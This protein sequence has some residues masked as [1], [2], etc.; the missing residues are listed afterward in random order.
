MTANSAGATMNQ[1]QPAFTL[2]ARGLARSAAPS[3]VQEMATLHAA[4][5]EVETA[6]DEQPLS[7]A[8]RG[9]EETA[10][11]GMARLSTD[12]RHTTLAVPPS[13]KPERTKHS[14]S[15]LQANSWPPP[16]PPPLLLPPSPRSPPTLCGQWTRQ[17]RRRLLMRCRPPHRQRV[18]PPRIWLPLQRRS[19]R[20]TRLLALPT[21]ASRT[22]FER[23]MRRCAR[24]TQLPS[25][26]RYAQPA[27]A[28]ASLTLAPYHLPRTLVV[29]VHP[30]L[31]P[32]LLAPPHVLTGSGGS[33]VAAGR[34][35]CGRTPSHDH[36][37]RHRCLWPRAMLDRAVQALRGRLQAGRDLP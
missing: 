5:Q 33:R 20:R 3:A 2:V 27:R 1:R 13:T 19:V 22:P 25:S 14:S 30:L 17:P 7:S 10:A 12:Q 23:R 11:S 21:Q 8:I 15:V 36:L 35:D 6:I 28:S 18:S 24:C 29:L 31:L 34:F 26:C 4:V 16:H 37:G 32:P 9:A